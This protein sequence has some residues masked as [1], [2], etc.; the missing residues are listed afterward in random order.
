LSFADIAFYM[1]QLFGD[2]MGE[3]MT[4]ATPRLLNWRARMTSRSS[5]RQVVGPMAAYLAAH[6]RKV[7]QWLLETLPEAR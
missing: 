6:G 3:P 2:R 4:D 7:P 5:V 1:A